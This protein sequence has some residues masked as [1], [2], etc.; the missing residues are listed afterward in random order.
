M[1]GVNKSKDRLRSDI[2]SHRCLLSRSS[3]TR[4]C[5]LIRG[6]STTNSH[7]LNQLIIVIVDVRPV[8]ICCPTTLLLTSKHLYL[9]MIKFWVKSRIT[10]RVFCDKPLRALSYRSYLLELLLL[11]LRCIYLIELW[12]D[13]FTGNSLSE[14]K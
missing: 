3:L 1:L 7:W 12:G 14:V 8:L 13:R 11:I 9:V 2:L 4:C 10:G 5:S 6:I